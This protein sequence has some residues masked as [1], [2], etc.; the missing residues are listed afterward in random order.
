MYSG[1]FR[2]FPA[3]QIM[4]IRIQLPS[5]KHPWYPNP[6]NARKVIADSRCSNIGGVYELKMIYVTIFGNFLVMCPSHNQFP[7]QLVFVT[8]VRHFKMLLIPINAHPPLVRGMLH[9]DVDP[10]HSSY[11]CCCHDGGVAALF[12]QKAFQHL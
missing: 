3:L 9:R 6:C 12:L 8:S 11:P 2:P 5:W 1:Q 7:L 4:A 10:L